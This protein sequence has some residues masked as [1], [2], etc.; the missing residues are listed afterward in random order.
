MLRSAFGVRDMAL[1]WFAS[2]LSGRTQHV[3][4]DGTLSTKSDLDFGVPKGSCLGPLFHFV[5]ASKIFKN[6]GQT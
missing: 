6:C 5:Y 2:Y 1:S 3:S 4:V